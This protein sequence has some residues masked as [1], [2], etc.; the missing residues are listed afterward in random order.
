M[1]AGKLLTHVV[2]FLTVG[3]DEKYQLP[4]LKYGMN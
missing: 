1:R 2:L 4:I 3:G